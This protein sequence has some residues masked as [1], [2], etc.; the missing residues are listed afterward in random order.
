MANHMLSLTALSWHTIAVETLRMRSRC[1]NECDF[2]ISIAPGYKILELHPSLKHPRTT[3]EITANR[4][5]VAQDD[6]M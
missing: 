2:E 5:H 4:G 1:N 3:P 6:Y